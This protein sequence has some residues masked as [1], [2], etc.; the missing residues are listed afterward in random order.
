MLGALD[1]IVSKHA[2]SRVLVVSHVTPIKTLV[3]QA[4]GA[5]L[6]SALRMELSPASV[7]AVAY[8]PDRA[9][10]ARAASL[11]AYNAGPHALA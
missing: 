8:F 1:R 2:G 4:L 10:G 3:A 6:Q 5:P 9:T 7:T 11:K